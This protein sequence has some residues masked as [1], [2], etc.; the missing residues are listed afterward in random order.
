MARRRKDIHHAGHR[1]PGGLEDLRTRTDRSAI[2]FH[3]ALSALIVFASAFPFLPILGYGFLNWDDP[4]VFLQNDRLTAAG[5]LAW[6]FTTSHMGHYQPLSWLAWAAIARAAGVTPAAMHALSLAG[7][8]LN[9]ALIYLLAS[10]LARAAGAAAPVRMWAPTVAAALFAVHPL[11]VEPVAWASAFPYILALAFALISTI[12]YVKAHTSAEAGLKAGLEAGLK[13][14]ATGDGTGRGWFAASVC[15]Y[16]LS[17]LA[18]PAAL[19]FPVALLAIDAYPLGRLR[20]TREHRAA[21][22][23][24]ILEK[25][26][27][28]ALAIAAAWL[29]ASARSVA[30]LEEVGM[31]A[32]LGLAVTAPLVY[33]WRTLWPAN[34]SP[35]DVLPIAPQTTWPRIAVSIV[36]LAAALVAFVKLRRRVPAAP[37]VAI[38][39]LALLA[40]AA[41]LTPSGLQA[42]A[43]R[44]TYLPVVPLAIAAGAGLA[45]LFGHPRRRIAAV[46]IA[47]AAAAALATATGR[48]VGWWRDSITVW[49][50]AATLD[51][52]N[53][54]ALYNLAS[55]L[56]EAGRADEAM[57]RYEDTL[58]LVPDH[59]LARRNLALLRAGRLEQTA[60]D[61]AASG[62]LDEA[63]ARYSEALALDP[64][65]RH[66]RASRGVAQLQRGRSADAVPDLMDVWREG[67]RRAPIANALGLALVETGRDAEAAG[68]LREAARLYPD[69]LDIAH[70]LARV[71]AISADP[72][73]RN[74]AEAVVFAE[75]V[76]QAT[77]GLDPRALDTLAAAYAAAG[78]IDL[79]TR[80]A[81]RAVEAA[82]AQGDAAVAAQ[83]R[84]RGRLYHRR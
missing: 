37:A 39:Y 23:R 61:L 50:R 66:S 73:V 78:R 17:L 52:R 16:A 10:R 68:V 42:T 24:A 45:T 70:N 30:S 4:D 5:A 27:Y 3:F 80:T 62:R 76:N 11:R 7:H 9:A 34:L 56:A 18:R 82:V 67:D 2:F 26:P 49:D 35:L 12:A 40:P 43:D 46:A 22:R 59:A 8:L 44:Y 55:A 15:A 13:P 71:L 81:A 14:C 19:G 77:G 69:D 65:R 32:R 79:A 57:A 25:L 38:A 60:N 83:L 72:G 33:L 36:A 41:G 48:Q 54:V 28:A 47:I 53:D 31:A 58:T 84:A 1:D 75:R 29:E 63:V 51:P 21:D 74:G 6:A 64:A 20:L